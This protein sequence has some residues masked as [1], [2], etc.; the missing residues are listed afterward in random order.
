MPDNLLEIPNSKLQIPDGRQTW[1]EVDL[2]ARFTLAPKRLCCS[3]Y[4]I[5]WAERLETIPYEILCVIAPPDSQDLYR[6]KA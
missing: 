6:S 4:A 5:D 2:D 1:A 3:L